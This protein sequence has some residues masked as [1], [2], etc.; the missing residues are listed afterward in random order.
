MRVPR[1]AAM[2]VAMMQVGVMRV[3]MDQR[4]VAMPMAVRFRGVDAGGVHVL[5]MGVVPMAVLMLQRVVGML[6]LVPFGQMQ[7]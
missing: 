7:P 3:A 5:V 2:A 4:R 1:R 6:M